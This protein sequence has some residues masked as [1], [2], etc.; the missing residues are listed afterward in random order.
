MMSSKEGGVYDDYIEGDTGN[1][2]IY[3]GG[4]NDYIYDDEGDDLLNGCAGNDS[5][6]GGNDN[7][8]LN[9]EAGNDSLSGAFGNDILDGGAGNDNLFGGSGDDT[10][11]GSSANSGKD[12]ISDDSVTD[13]ASFGS[14]VST[15]VTFTAE[16]FDGDG[17]FDGLRILINT[18]NYVDIQNY[19]DDSVT[20]ASGQGSITSADF[21]SSLIESLVFNDATL[22]IADFVAIL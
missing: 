15:A 19:F 1:D 17:S 4:D 21:G 12:I 6:D 18:N 14:I 8:T 3:G 9:G 13:T 10:Y 7:D 5:I 2:Q 22:A 20:V 11:N 16:D